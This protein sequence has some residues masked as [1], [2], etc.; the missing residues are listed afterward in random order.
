MAINT[1]G[2][3]FTTQHASTMDHGPIA[4]SHSSEEGRFITGTQAGNQFV[5]INYLQMRLSIADTYCCVITC[6]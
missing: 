1:L 4:I 5:E 3:R 2:Q 6:S